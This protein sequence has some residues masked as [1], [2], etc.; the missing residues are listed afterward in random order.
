MTLGTRAQEFSL[1]T[2]ADYDQIMVNSGA[3]P[4]ITEGN[5]PLATRMLLFGAKV[6]SGIIG[7]K[8]RQRSKG[9]MT[10]TERL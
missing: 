4:E 9:R 10:M 7:A 1:E 8:A 3:N 5:A 6:G 2:E